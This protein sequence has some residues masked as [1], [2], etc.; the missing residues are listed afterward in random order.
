MPVAD[1][2]IAGKEKL[3]MVK[4]KCSIIVDGELPHQMQ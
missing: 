2:A 1:L 4:P 3:S